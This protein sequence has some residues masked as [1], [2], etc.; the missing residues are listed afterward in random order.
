METLK[1][2]KWQP[3]LCPQDIFVDKHGE[4]NAFLE[5]NPAL[6][7]NHDN[8][9]ILLI[10]L[11]NYRKFKNRAFKIG[12]N[13]SESKYYIYRGKLDTEGNLC[14]EKGESLKITNHYKKY[15]SVWQ[16]YEDIRFL[17][18]KQLIMTAPEYNPSGKPRLVLGVLIGSEVVVTRLLEP[19]VIEKNWMP[20]A[21][22]KVIYSVS[23]LANKPLHGGSIEILHSAEE[24]H[25]YHGST[26]GVQLDGGA[27]L[28][29][30]HKFHER[31]EH[32]WLI[33]DE[34]KGEFGYSEPFAFHTMSYIEFPCTLSRHG[35]MYYV[36]LGIN[37]DKAFIASVKCDVVKITKQIKM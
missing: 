10:R 7:I 15:Y 22:E 21:D 26:N 19:S 2:E 13:C 35:D 1:V 16:G 17:N 24:L 34:V 32:R 18:S 36:G 8:T 14:I 27:W 20:F 29:L 5:T 11:I 37:D 4:Y 3:L 23:P 6:W 9:F 28:F 12:G 31:T 25:G 30:I 33:L